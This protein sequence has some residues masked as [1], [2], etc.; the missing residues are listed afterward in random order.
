MI[1]LLF[2]SPPLDPNYPLVFPH[3]TM[4]L[5]QL[6]EMIFYT[7]PPIHIVNSNNKYLEK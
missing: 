1:R 3:H 5:K 6:Y 2:L 7:F 4:S